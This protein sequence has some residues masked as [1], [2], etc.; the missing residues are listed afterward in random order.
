MAESILGKINYLT[1]EQYQTAKANGQINENEIYM[2]PTETTDFETTKIKQEVLWTGSFSPTADNTYRY[3]TLSKNVYDYDFLLVDVGSG[4]HLEN[5]TTVV[6]TIEGKGV[7]CA[8]RSQ[9]FYLVDSYCFTFGVITD[10]LN[11]IGFKVQKYKNYSLSDMTMQRIVGIK[12]NENRIYKSIND[13]T[14]DDTI[15]STNETPIG[16]WVNG[17]PLYRKVFTTISVNGNSNSTTAH[18]ISNLDTIARYTAHSYYNGVFRPVTYS[19]GNT[20]TLCEIDKTNIYVY[21]TTANPYTITV[22][23]EY[24]KTTD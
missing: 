8:V 24:T 11:Q 23:V 5:R 7:Q 6:L 20:Y 21:N 14:H 13:N 3:M 12:L 18:G 16:T 2:T 17:K 19:A 15:Y 9:L 4:T 10:G 22:I 1:E